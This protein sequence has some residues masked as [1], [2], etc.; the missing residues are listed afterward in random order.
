M[1]K[2]GKNLDEIL[3]ERKEKIVTFM[4][5]SA[6]I[7]LNFNELVNVL[8]V[9]SEDIGLFKMVLEELQKEGKIFKTKKDRYSLTKKMK[10]VVG[11]LQGNE[12]GYGFVIPDSGEGEDVFIPAEHM[13][14]AMH[15][16]RVVTKIISRR[17]GARSSEGEVVRVIERAND[18]VVG[19]YESDKHFGF[20]IPDD[21]R[22]ES[23]HIPFKK[24]AGARDGQKVVAEILKWPTS[25]IYAGG[26]VVEILGYAD[27]PGVDIVSVIRNHKL[28]E[29]FPEEVVK[30]A[31]TIPPGVTADAVIGRRDLRSLKMVTIDNED[32][33]DLDDAV[34]L[35]KLDNGHYRLGVHIADVSYYVKEGSEL[36]KEAL[37]RG[38]SVYLADRVLPML[39]P[40]LSNGICSLNPNVDR[41]AFTVMMEIDPTGKVVGHEIFE[42]VINTDRRLTYTDVYGIVEKQDESLKEKLRELAETLEAMKELA[43]ILRNKRMRRGSLDFDFGETKVI[44][45]EKG[46]PV[47]VMRYEIT[48]ANRI[49]EEFMIVCNE[50]VAEHFFWMDMPFLYRV[51]E[52]PEP[53]KMQ[54]FAEFA[55]NLGYKLRMAGGIQPRTLQELLN[56]VKGTREERL[57]NMVMLR[58]LQKAKYSHSNLGH[59]GLASECYCHFTAPIRR[60]PDLIIHRIMKDAIH[61]R[62]N[63]KIRERLAE[64]LPEIARHCSEREQAAEEAER[65]TVD[66]KK[67]EYMKQYVGEVFEGIISN[68]TPFGMF[69]ELDNTVEGLVRLSDMDDDYYIH[70]ERNYTLTGERM[71]KVYKIGKSVKVRVVR[72]DAA[73]RQID[74]VLA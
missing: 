1:K 8:A 20:V 24:S 58:S 5:D 55:F 2:K 23:I 15:N 6:Y 38:T 10:L 7:P 29:E 12:R 66:M 13:N 68:V 49:I 50:T 53:E 21:P 11:R 43:L 32:A 74:F 59:F 52:E 14:G 30:E 26:R 60:Y 70:N 69:V 71:G 44:L 37:K 63:E 46:K 72:A 62:I 19:T 56:K 40:E 57:V 31:E 27:E 36:D 22:L 61:N 4:G 42:S 41:L 33:K 48:I 34:S 17:T 64:K 28:R 25:E 18:R 35:E 39:P 47:D 73:S 54:L 45:D 67:A 51:H 3:N 16:D 9:P 65:E